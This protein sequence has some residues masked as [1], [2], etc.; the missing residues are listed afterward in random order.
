M[1]MDPRSK[2]RTNATGR[3]KAVSAHVRFYWW[4]LESAAYRSLCPVAR[5]VLLELKAL[6]NGTNNGSLFLSAREA[7][8]RVGVG[9]SKAW[10]ALRDLQMR[11]II[12]PAVKGGFSWKTGSRRGDATAWILTEFPIGNEKG[13]GTR[14]FMRWKEG[15]DLAPERN[16]RSARKDALSATTN[17]AS[18]DADAHPEN[19]LYCPSPRTELDQMARAASVAADTDKLPG[20]GEP[21]ADSW[22]R[23]RARALL[24]SAVASARRLR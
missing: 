7:G 1:T 24:D 9:K 21:E 14:E 12:R 22:K 10:E 16:R 15:D 17:G 2:R 13:V 8:R 19:T 3:S 5:C 20:G 23:P 4:E 6:Y 11:G 18:V